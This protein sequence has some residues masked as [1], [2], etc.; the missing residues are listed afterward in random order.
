M[1]AELSAKR[2]TVVVEEKGKGGIQELTQR[3]HDEVQSAPWLLLSED[4]THAALRAIALDRLAQTSGSNDTHPTHPTLVRQTDERQ[5]APS[6]SD[7]LAL[8]AKKLGA[9]PNAL[10]AR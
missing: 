3:Q 6:S 2:P 8:N 5:I 10:G 4:L 7:T 1:G 9:A